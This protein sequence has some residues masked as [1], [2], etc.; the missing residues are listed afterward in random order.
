MD[1]LVARS[2][3][4][5]RKALEHLLLDCSTMVAERISKRLRADARDQD[6]FQDILRQTYLVAV[7]GIQSFRQH[8]FPS[9]RAWILQIADC[10][11]IGFVRNAKARKRGDDRER[12]FI[13]LNE[14]S[15]ETSR[16]SKHLRRKEMEVTKRDG[17]RS[18]SALATPAKTWLESHASPQV[19]RSRLTAHCLSRNARKHKRT[20]NS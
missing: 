1:E 18:Q 19:N 14:I 7:H 2:V 12:A 10:C 16:P 5:D 6:N 15:A 11:V 13:E 4:G 20:L 3:S 17:S 9:F 8:D